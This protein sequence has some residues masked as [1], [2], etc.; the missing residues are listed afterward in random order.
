MRKCESSL[1]RY[2]TATVAVGPSLGN[3]GP[4]TTTIGAAA[5]LAGTAE[6]LAEKR[7]VVE[8]QSFGVSGDVGGAAGDCYANPD[9]PGSGTDSCSCV[10]CSLPGRKIEAA[11]STRKEKGR[12]RQNGKRMRAQEVVGKKSFKASFGCCP[13]TG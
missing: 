6:H 7:S 1:T 10:P 11:L 4:E 2:Q 5:G 13:S 3:T 8:R 9:R 12:Q